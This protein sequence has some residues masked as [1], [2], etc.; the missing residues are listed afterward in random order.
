MDSLARPISLDPLSGN[1]ICVRV[2]FGWPCRR[3]HRRGS[4]NREKR[5]RCGFYRKEQD[6]DCL[7]DSVGQSLFK[8]RVDP[9][10]LNRAIWIKTRLSTGTNQYHLTGMV[11]WP[12]ARLVRCTHTTMAP[13]IM[14]NLTVP[15]STLSA[16]S[17]P[18][19]SIPLAA[20]DRR[21]GF[22]DIGGWAIWGATL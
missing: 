3:L 17:N 7:G 16:F 5:P 15:T 20:I 18:N 1:L 19:R 13:T 8:P 9:L 2:L 6:C 10:M 4:G 12:L 14:G 22:A 21:E 11:V